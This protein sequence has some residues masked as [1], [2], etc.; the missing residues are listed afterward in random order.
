MDDDLE[1]I[2]K[3]FGKIQQ[4]EARYEV[5]ASAKIYPNIV[6]I[7]IPKTPY[8]KNIPYIE[9]HIDDLDGL[10]E[11]W[12]TRVK[13]TLGSDEDNIERSL[14]RTKTLISDIVL[15]N[16]F[17]LF[18]TFTF[19]PEKTTDRNNPRLIKIQMSN[20]L[21]NQRKRNGKFKYLIVPEFHK[22]RKAIHFH[23]LLQ[24]YP[25]QLTDS[26]RNHKG[27][28]IYHF[29][30]YTLGFNTAVQID[31]PEKVSSYVR[32]YITKDMPQFSGQHRF[33]ASSGLQRPKVIDNPDSSLYSGTLLR[34]YENEYGQILYYEIR[35]E[36]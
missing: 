31:N 34:T 25:G 12:P 29:S 11:D 3:V 26:G 24:G 6:K 22:D 36:E 5:T 2:I 30:G 19:D 10:V 4:A 18:A 1:N 20:W 13:Q 14:R 16:E 9:E 32:K 33:W 23:A 17:D 27:R 8:Y 21:R 7:F 15:C 35:N 28:R